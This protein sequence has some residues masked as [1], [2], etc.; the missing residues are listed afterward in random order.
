MHPK[1]SGLIFVSV[2][3]LNLAA[4]IVGFTLDFLTLEPALWAAA[5]YGAAC[6]AV[7]PIC[8]RHQRRNLHRYSADT[9]NMIV[10]SW[11]VKPWKNIAII[12][13]VMAMSG[14]LAFSITGAALFTR[15]VG[16]HDDRTFTVAN[17]DWVQGRLRRCYEVT[18]VEFPKLG[19]MSSPP[20]YD[21]KIPAGTRLRFS[22]YHSSLGSWY[23]AIRV[24]H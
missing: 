19:Q 12:S 14:Y 23:S 17:S 4:A 7:F 10:R 1:Y 18:L 13:A 3:I 11:G 22:G 15:L 9:A 5:L 16:N 6:A 8:V 24:E 21:Q 2:L 20:C